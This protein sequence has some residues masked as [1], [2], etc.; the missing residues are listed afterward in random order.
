MGKICPKFG[1]QWGGFK[2]SSRPTLRQDRIHCTRKLGQLPSWMKSKRMSVRGK[3]YR[4]LSA[5]S[6]RSEFPE[7]IG[8]VF[9]RRAWIHGLNIFLDIF[10]SVTT[11]PGYPVIVVKLAT[12]CPCLPRFKIVKFKKRI[13]Q[14]EYCK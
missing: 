12:T 14:G 10:V 6:F 8:L 2:K 9:E 1:R 13:L 11:P 4:L 5:S 7:Y 3:E